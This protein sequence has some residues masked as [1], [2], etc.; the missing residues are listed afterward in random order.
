[1]LYTSTGR[2]GVAIDIKP[3]YTGIG[4]LIIKLILPYMNRC[5]SLRGPCAKGQGDL[6]GKTFQ[7]CLNMTDDLKLPPPYKSLDLMLSPHY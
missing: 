6:V 3:P 7:N 2:A 5:W 4:K 1:M